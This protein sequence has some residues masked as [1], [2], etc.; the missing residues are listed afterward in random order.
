M[1]TALLLTSSAASGHGG[2]LNAEGCHNNRKTGE[3]H[4]HRGPKAGQGATQG[5]VA[6]APAGPVA[7]GGGGRS[8]SERLQELKA[9]RDQGL[10]TPEQYKQKQAEILKDL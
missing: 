10:I 6:P 2:G 5:F 3:Y 7:G 4:C 1:V 9:L 8:A